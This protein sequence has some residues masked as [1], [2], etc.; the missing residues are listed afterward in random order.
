MAWVRV[1]DA[2]KLGVSKDLSVHELPLG[3]WTDAQNIRF[4]DGYAWQAFGWGQVYGS[5]PI[6]PQYILPCEVSGQKYAILAGSAKVE[7]VTIVSGVAT[8]YDLTPTSARTGTANNWT[9][10]L[11]SGI[12]ILN[13]GD[14]AHYPMFW[15]ENT[16]TPFADL[17]NWPTSTYCQS[18][19]AFKNFL[20]ALNVT[21]GTT[22]YP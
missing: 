11:L 14:G 20:I 10:T 5:I 12:P 19:R 2:G 15:N 8:Y 21:K 1:K 13:A 18:L 17:T 22:T 4:L 7:A 6:T 9:G 3:A 16:G